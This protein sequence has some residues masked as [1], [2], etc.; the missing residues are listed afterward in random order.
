MQD[1]DT[2]TALLTEM[3]EGAF[4]ASL[5]GE[6]V[7]DHAGSLDEE[8]RNIAITGRHPV[9]IDCS[10]VNR[11]DTAGAILIRKLTAHLAPAGP[12][13]RSNLSPK[14]DHLLEMVENSFER[15]DCMPPEPNWFTEL[16]SDIGKS[17]E[18]AALNLGQLLSFIGFILATLAR[19]I[20][21]PW[22]FRYK[23]MI[24]QLEAVGL[25][26]LGIVGLISFLIGAVMVNQGSIQLAKFG[27][28]I[29]VIDMLG[30]THLRELGVLLTAIIVA[31]RSGSAFTAQIGSMKIN[32]EIDAMKT[33]GLSPMEV[34]VIPRFIALVIAMPLLT[35]YADVLGILGGAT[36]A[37]VQLDISF[38]SFLVYLQE[39]VPLTHYWVGI[40]KAPAFAAVIAVSGCYEGLSVKNNADSLGY[41]TTKSVVQSIFL[42]IILD[43][44]FAIFF[45][46]LNM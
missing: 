20:F 11:L 36:M 34:L 3:K 27:A 23:A 22:R 10:R 16:V 4:R 14:Y 24:I 12:V 19:V 44:L 37:A 38:A 32:E 29:L 21:M 45:T 1:R 18:S 25:R 13:S 9:E 43:A 5:I 8:I 33:L 15:A 35:V 17:I 41:H 6:W 46:A 42:V 30:I 40:L 39:E 2:K 7:V 31:G 28:D 26:A